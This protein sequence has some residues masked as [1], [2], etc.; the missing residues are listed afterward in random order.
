MQLSRVLSTAIFCFA[1]IALLGGCSTKTYQP[2]EHSI[3]DRDVRDF[4]VSG[5]IKVS[6]IN[7]QQNPQVIYENFGKFESSYQ[8]IAS[9]MAAQLEKEIKENSTIDGDRDKDL[10]IQL[11]N[12]YMTPG[13]STADFHMDFTVIGERGF[14]KQF[15]F[16]E[17]GSQF[18]GL[19]LEQSFNSAIAM[20]VKKI[21]RDGR[22]LQ[23]M[24]SNSIY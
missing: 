1:A 8:E 5:N 3:I 11:D 19:G 24:A 17:S 20:S 16:Q 13:A 18:S 6:S 23:Y 14:E 2:Q 12:F 10:Y 7:M 21:L 4:E 22:T 9:L 15:Q